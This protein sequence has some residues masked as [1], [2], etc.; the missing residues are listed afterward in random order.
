MIESANWFL[1]TMCKAEI[2]R[3]EL[4]RELLGLHMKCRRKLKAKI[5]QKDFKVRSDLRA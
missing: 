5:Q 1:F 2:E 4:K 3:D